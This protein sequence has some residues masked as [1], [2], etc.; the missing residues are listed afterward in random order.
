MT[1]GPAIEDGFYYD[2]ARAEP[3]TPEDLARIEDGHARDRGQGRPALRAAGDVA[4]GGHRLLPRA[5]RAYKVEILEGIAADRVSLYRQGDFIDLCR[6]PHVASTGPGARSSSSSPR[7]APTGG[8]TRR[9]RCCSGST[10][11]PGSRQEE[12]DKLSVAAGGGQEA[13]PPQAR[14]RARSVRVPRRRARA[15]RSGCP[16]A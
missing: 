11:P 2:F 9:T 6:G 5:R 16:T 15:R 8:A 10:A 3:F 1:I 14:A 12:L 7:R 13:R 4:R